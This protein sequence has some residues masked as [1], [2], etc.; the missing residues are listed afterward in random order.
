MILLGSV[1]DSVFTRI[2]SASA[3]AASN[4]VDLSPDIDPTGRMPSNY[5]WCLLC[6]SASLSKGDE[7]LN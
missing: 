1:C 4:K 7:S 2:Q 5:Q 3:W 6:G